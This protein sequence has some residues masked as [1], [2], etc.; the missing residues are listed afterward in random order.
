[1]TY[2][3]Y[4]WNNAYTLDDF[5]SSTYSLKSFKHMS[6]L[7]AAEAT[8]QIEQE[9]TNAL[10]INPYGS[11]F[12]EVNEEDVVINLLQGDFEKKCGISFERFIEV[13][14]EILKNN[15]EKLI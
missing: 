11:N 10:G 12:Q 14:N 4:K 15:P 7:L 8:R 1:M 2:K 5:S 3:P 13:Y 9:F 6:E